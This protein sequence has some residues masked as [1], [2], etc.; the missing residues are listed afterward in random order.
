MD[1]QKRIQICWR[2]AIGTSL[3]AAIAYV[4]E[5]PGAIREARYYA[6]TIP[7]VGILAAPV[8]AI[9]P[10]LKIIGWGAIAYGFAHLF[11]SANVPPE[12]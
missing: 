3:F 8:V 12:H 11:T 9:A 4:P 10:A 2:I 7:L 6:G 5:F 1:R